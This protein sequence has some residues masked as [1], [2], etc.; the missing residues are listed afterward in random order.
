MEI[1]NFKNFMK[2]YGLKNDTTNELELQRVYNYP[3]YS[4]VSKI[5]SDKR[6]VNLDDFCQGGTHW[7]CF[8]VK[9]KNH[10]IL[11]HLEELL[12]NFYPIN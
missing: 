10:S 5:Y 12:I 3:I 11:T 6:F 9:Q 1:S 8:I 2:K 4:R 7:T